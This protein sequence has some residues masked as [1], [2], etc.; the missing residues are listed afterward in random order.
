LCLLHITLISMNHTTETYKG[1]ILTELFK[2]RRR[3]QKG[4]RGRGGGNPR[5]NLGPALPDS[6][7][8]QL[9]SSAAGPQRGGG[10]GRGRKSSA[11]NRKQARKAAR[12][13]KKQHRVDYQQRRV[14]AL[15][16][17]RPGSDVVSLAAA[18]VQ[19]LL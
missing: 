17:K 19:P 12:E 9:G 13:S 6:L 7:L 11:E 14:T 18:T 10:G 15:G 5:F 3:M 1:N 4:R 2:E 16:K 8:Q